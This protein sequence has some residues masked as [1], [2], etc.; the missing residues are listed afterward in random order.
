[1]L[2]RDEK[3]SLEALTSVDSAAT[4]TLGPFFLLSRLVAP[5]VQARNE[6]EKPDSESFTGITTNS[7]PPLSQPPSDL[8]FDPPP[9]TSIAPC[10]PC[11]QPMYSSSQTALRAPLQSL[12]NS[13]PAFPRTALRRRPDKLNFSQA[14][15]RFGKRVRFEDE[16]NP[17]SD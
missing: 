17:S 16:A 1:M 4:G 14:S 15:Q 12:S 3:A 6:E 13:H 10:Y 8:G 2:N 7:Q 5:Y 9:S 11:S